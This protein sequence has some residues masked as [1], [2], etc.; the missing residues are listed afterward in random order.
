MN[1]V[2]ENAEKR[3]MEARPWLGQD[4]GKFQGYSHSCSDSHFL[5]NS[6]VCNWLKSVG[7]HAVLAYVATRAVL[8]DMFPSE[9]LRLSN[10]CFGVE[11]DVQHKSS[12]IPS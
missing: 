1:E 4:Y 6:M 8:A 5:F 9:Y 10:C 11:L 3:S 12:R 2:A 7:S